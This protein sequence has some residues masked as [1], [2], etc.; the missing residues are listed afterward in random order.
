MGRIGRFIKEWVR[1]ALLGKSWGE[2]VAKSGSLLA[3]LGLSF[4][5]KQQMT[6]VLATKPQAISLVSSLGILGISILAF[7]YLFFTAGMAWIRSAGHNL[8]VGDELEFDPHYLT[9]RLRVTNKSHKPAMVIVEMDKIWSDHEGAPTNPAIFPLQLV[10]SDTNDVFRQELPY[11]RPKTVIVVGLNPEQ[12]SHKLYFRVWG[13]T[14]RN[15]LVPLDGVQNVY[16]DLSIY[17]PDHPH[18]IKRRF[19][20]E[21]NTDDH[22]KF[23]VSSIKESAWKQLTSTQTS[24]I[25]KQDLDPVE[26][27]K[28]MIPSDPEKTSTG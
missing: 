22:F 28:V 19:L 13:A 5:F 17:R 23:K 6:L 10:W 18:S 14:Y 27:A 7:T 15:F 26:N 11:D 8:L 3:G 20:F 21:R 16:C 4:F 9:W 25:P 12:T 1:L 2:K 24:P